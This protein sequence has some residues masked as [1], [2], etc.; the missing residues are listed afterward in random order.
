MEKV[1]GKGTFRQYHSDLSDQ[2]ALEI[3]VRVTISAFSWRTKKTS[4]LFYANF[5]QGNILLKEHTQTINNKIKLHILGMPVNKLGDWL[6]PFYSTPFHRFISGNEAHTKNTK[7]EQDDRRSV[8]R[9]SIEA[10]KTHSKTIKTETNIH[11]HLHS[12][13]HLSQSR[14]LSCDVI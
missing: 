10:Q 14:L 12:M 13:K 1:K 6:I 4:T 2:S 11:V 7:I 5:T 9:K 3:R 8:Q